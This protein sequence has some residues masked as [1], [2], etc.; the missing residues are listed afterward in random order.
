[1]THQTLYFDYLSSPF[2]QLEIAATKHKLYS[3]RFV[4]KH[5]H[6]TEANI[7][8]AEAKQQLT[9]YFAGSRL[10]F[11]L[12]LENDGTLFQQLVWQHLCAIPY[13]TSCTYGDIA[14]IIGRPK[15]VRAV[16]AANGRNRIA[17]IVPCH[18]VVGANGC[19]TGY[20]WGVSVKAGLLQHEQNCLNKR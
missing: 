13:G 17:I 11:D 2:G 4:S 14:K 6:T 5:L 12:P 16:G 9:E 8:A 20:A 18:R 3:V 1:M 7:I 15:A 19:L 10:T